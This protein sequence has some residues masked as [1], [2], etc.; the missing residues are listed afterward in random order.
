MRRLRGAALVRG[1][2]GVLE[3]AQ[4]VG[5][6]AV[7]GAVVVVEAGGGGEGEGG[8]KGGEDGGGGGGDGGGEGAEEGEGGGDWL[9]VGV[10]GREWV[11]GED[12]VFGDLRGGCVSLRW[13]RR[14]GR[15]TA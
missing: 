1:L 7:Q 9:R 8:G 12:G 5:A 2:R 3:Q 13:G 6:G 15:R 11:E 14:E 10:L 4:Q